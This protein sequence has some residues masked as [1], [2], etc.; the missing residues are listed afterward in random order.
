[1]DWRA[2]GAVSSVK[3]QGKCASC[4]AFT[5]AGAIESI[6]KIKK[7]TLYDLSPQQIVDCSQGQRN[8]GCRGGFM[9]NAYNYLNGNKLMKSADYP[10]T[11]VLG[12]CKYVSS[13]GVT[14]VPS[15]KVLPKNDVNAILNA[16]AQQPVS[17]G[18]SAFCGSFMLYKGGIITKSCGSVLNH[19]V[20]IVGYG[21]TNG[22][23]FWIIKNSWGPS[24][25][26]Q[27][28]FRILRT[29][30]AGIGG[31]NSLASYPNV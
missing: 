12:S 19:A 14:N 30:G 24:W 3:D 28:Y 1:M 7:G 13:K 2:Q 21:S 8:S 10:Y 5:A 29:A 26:E 23:D 15:H 6:Y 11:G 17:I 9:T 16:V 22:Q 18:M 31:I 27:G 20:L 4:Y 25:G